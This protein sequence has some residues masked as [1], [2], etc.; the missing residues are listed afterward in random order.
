MKVESTKREIDT[1]ISWINVT[2]HIQWDLP[3]EILDHLDKF[4]YLEE[5]VENLKNQV[6]YYYELQAHQCKSAEYFA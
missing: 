2:S 1:L 3:L 4:D 6:Q 5:Y